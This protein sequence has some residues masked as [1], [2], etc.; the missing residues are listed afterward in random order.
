MIWLLLLFIVLELWFI[1]WLH[2]INH[3]RRLRRMGW[4]V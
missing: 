4:D 2:G 1:Y 3:R